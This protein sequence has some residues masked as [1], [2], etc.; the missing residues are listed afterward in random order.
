MEGRNKERKKWTGCGRHQENARQQVRLLFS[1]TTVTK[2]TLLSFREIGG[3]ISPIP[4]QTHLLGCQS[5]FVPPDS[6]PVQ[7][8]GRLT[9]WMG[10]RIELPCLLTSSWVWPM[11]GTDSRVEEERSW[12]TSSH[13]LLCGS[14]SG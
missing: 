7:R 10:P 5:P 4:I 14:G 13:F 6:C 1:K 11:G 9:P 12:G 3:H 2:L 8:I